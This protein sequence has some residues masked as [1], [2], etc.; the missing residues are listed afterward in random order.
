MPARKV[1]IL[2]AAGRDFHNF[3]MVYRDNPAY[4]VVAFTAAQIPGIA[5]RRYPRE[6]AGRKYPKGIPIFPEERMRDVIRRSGADLVVLSYSDLPYAEVMHKASIALA[7]GADF[8]LLGPKSTMLKS[9]KPV[10]AVTAVRTGAGKSPTV[11]RVCDILRRLGHR[12]IVIRHPMPYG[13]FEAVQRFADVE[14]L[15]R[16][17]STIEEME[18]YGPHIAAGNVVYA[19]V[20]YEKVLRAAEKE[21]DVIV[22]DGGN[23]DL[24]FI[25]PNLH[26]TVADARRPGH[27]LAY[28]PG[29]A[30]FRSADV[31]IISKVDSAHPDDVE[32]VSRNA[33]AVNPK[34]LQIKAALAITID[35]PAAIRGK[36]VLVIEDGPTITHGGLSTGAGTLAA[37][38]QG[39]YIVNPRQYAVGSIKQAYAQYPNLGAALP[40]MGYSTEQMA[41]LDKTINDV[42]AD[43]VVFGTPIDL[44]H[45]MKINKPAVRVRYELREVGRPDLEDVIKSALKKR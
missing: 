18:E 3:N 12:V 27:E 25:A 37:E 32:T 23:N 10:I 17:K 4:N 16:H 1:V 5:G 43:A 40:A 35:D 41:E 36:R 9:K 38:S 44:R 13:K 2:G 29:E 11:R 7:A 19:G 22:W 21:A 33:T 42:P 31:I 26:I 14:D 8:E 24:P 30:N 45:F 6:L 34:A 20:D 15:K 39:A 28:Y